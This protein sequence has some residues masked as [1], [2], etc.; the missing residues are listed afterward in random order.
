MLATQELSLQASSVAQPQF[1][2]RPETFVVEISNCATSSV[3][4]KSGFT[5]IRIENATTEVRLIAVQLVDDGDPISACA[6]M[7]I[8]NATRKLTE[9]A[10][11]TKL[12][13][14]DH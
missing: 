3:A 7:S 8:A 12:L 2:F 6:V 4:R 14:L 5:T 9:I 11:F 13:G 10:N 1:I